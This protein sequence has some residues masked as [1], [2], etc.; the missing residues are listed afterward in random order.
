M[1]KKSEAAKEGAIPYLK[2]IFI[3]IKQSNYMNI[4]RRPSSIFFKKTYLR[5]TQ[6]K[7]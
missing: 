1:E 6:A 7:P 2:K 5:T 4:I 3:K